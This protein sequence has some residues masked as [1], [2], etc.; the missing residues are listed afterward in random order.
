MEYYVYKHTRLKDGSVFYIGKGK[1]DRYKD[2][3]GRN[4][5]WNRIVKKDGGFN[6]E[7]I[8]EGL[9]NAEACELEK[10]LINEIGINN[11]SNQAEGG[12]GGNTRKG[13]TKEEYARWLENKSKG[14]MGR[15][16]FWKGKKR[17]EH[18]K[19]MKELIAE[20]RYKGN[21][22]GK[23]KSEEHKEKLSE[24]A[25]NRKRVMVKCDICG[26]EV[27]NTHLAVHQRGTKCLVK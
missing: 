21:N 11:L 27:P 17:P 20:G 13:F 22:K 18:S 1:E 6:A 9:T 16:S 23:P 2:D 14:S 25:K 3:G 7:L 12:N 10:K 5:H 26:K 4:Q 24:A 19:R 8:K 15:K